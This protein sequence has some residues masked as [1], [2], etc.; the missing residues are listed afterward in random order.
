MASAA[1]KIRVFENVMARVG[2]DGN[3]L[4]E[5]FKGLSTINGMQTMT[6][7]NPPM[8]PQPQMGTSAPLSPQ[9]GTMSPLGDQGLPTGLNQPV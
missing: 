8:P 4:E 3:F 6:E 5:Y 1:D 9:N 7:M 2:L